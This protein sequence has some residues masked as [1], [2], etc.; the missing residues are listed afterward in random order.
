MQRADGGDEHARA[1][2]VTSSRRHAPKR[3]L[4]IPVRFDHFRVKANFRT[5]AKGVDHPD[6][7]G[8]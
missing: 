4:L 7:I 3:G 8:L 1:D 2:D 6:D 5:K